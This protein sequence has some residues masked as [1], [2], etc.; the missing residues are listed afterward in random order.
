RVADAEAFMVH[1]LSDPAT[2]ATVAEGMVRVLEPLG[3]RAFPLFD[4]LYQLPGAYHAVIRRLMATSDWPELQRYAE[5]SVPVIGA[6]AWLHQAYAFSE[7]QQPA[8]AEVAYGRAISADPELGL[9]WHNLGV[10]SARRE[11]WQ[12]ARLAFEGALSVA[13]ASFP[14]MIELIEVLAKLGDTDA[15]LPIFQEANQL[16]P[17]HPEVIR[18][19]EVLG[20][21]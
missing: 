12:T 14:A 19:A 9:A 5:A 20:V 10:L 3:E 11:D 6:E 17:E 8:E 21:R 16:L 2:P 4:R 1:A 18:L 15:A 7:L 13:P